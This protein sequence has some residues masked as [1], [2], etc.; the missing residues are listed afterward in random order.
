M[1]NPDTAPVPHPHPNNTRTMKILPRVVSASLLAFA[2]TVATAPAAPVPPPLTPELADLEP[3]SLLPASDADFEFFDLT[4]S[5]TPA[6]FVTLDEPDS[7]LA[8]QVTVPVRGAKL[9]DVEAK[10]AVPVAVQEGDVVLGRF[11]ARATLAR[12][13]S[14]EGSFGFSFGRAVEPHERSVRFTATPGPEWALFEVPFV[15]GQTYAAG[16]AIVTFTFGALVQNLEISGLQVLNFSSRASLEQLPKLQFTYRGREADAEWRTAALERI[17]KI[18]TAPLTIRVVNSAGE[19][20]EGARVDAQMIES[21]FIFGTAIDDRRLIGDTPDSERY[22]TAILE[23]FNTVVIENGLKWPAWSSGPGRQASARAALDWISQNGLR[24]KGHNLVWPAWKFSPS[25]L[26]ERDD[27]STALPELIS[28]RIAEMVEVT[29][30]RSYGWDVVNE[31]LHARDFFEH[32]PELSMADWF[33][34]ARELDPDAELYINDYSMLNS[35]LSPGT[36]M[37]LRDVTN[38]LRRAGAPI[39]G[40]GI[41][42][43]VGQQP[44]DPVAVL[45]DLD[46]MAEEGLP[47]QITEFDVNTP[48]EALQA[49]YTRDFLIACYSHPAVTG[50][51]KWGFWEAQHWKPDAA[52]FRRDWSEKPNAAVWREW[53]TDKWHTRLDEKTSADGAVSLRGHLGRYRITVTHDG[54]TNRQDVILPPT[55]ANVTVTFP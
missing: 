28:A 4:G 39:D 30:G 34:Q 8:Y 17:E 51:I 45:S 49:D 23:L 43:H 44:R 55:G 42:G 31:P 33:K 50:F 11:M 24:H 5:E 40:I 12:Q 18:R 6:T 7:G 15:V 26:Q 13:E 41:Q 37:R 32:I 20:L 38:R 10:I 47:I 16:E 1:G 25:S 2:F 46:L 14:G 3:V 27:L 53:V 29:R 9:Y 48:D 52:M 35:A 54:L 19:P 21:A 36:I 22:R